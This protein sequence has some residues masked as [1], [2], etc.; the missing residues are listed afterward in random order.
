LMVWDDL[1]FED[2]SETSASGN[3][4]AKL[5][6]KNGYGIS[7][8]FHQHKRYE[9]AV[10]KGVEEAWDICYDTSVAS[11]VLHCANSAAVDS[12]MRLIQKLDKT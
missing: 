2:I 11:D 10:L 12:Y 4:R 9:V 1:V 3:K 8:L 5:F 6:F 7:V